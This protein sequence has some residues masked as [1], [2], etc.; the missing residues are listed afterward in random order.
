MLNLGLDENKT[1]KVSRILTRT[2]EELHNASSMLYSASV[3]LQKQNL[4][5]TQ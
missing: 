4:N 2:A 5:S 1:D 3:E